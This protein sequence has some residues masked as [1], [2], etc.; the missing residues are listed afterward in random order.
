ML[1]SLPSRS[2]RSHWAQDVH[3]EPERKE[4]VG[5]RRLPSVNRRL[6]KSVRNLTKEGGAR[7]RGPPPGPSG[8]GTQRRFEFVELDEVEPAQDERDHAFTRQVQLEALLVESA[9]HDVDDA[10]G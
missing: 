4:R 10:R 1:V 5:R 7:Q 9:R 6:P 3:A 8:P 2:G